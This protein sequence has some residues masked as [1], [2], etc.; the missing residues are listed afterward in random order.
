M[1]AC[2]VTSAAMFLSRRRLE[3]QGLPGLYPFGLNPIAGRVHRSHKTFG[4]L[5]PRGTAELRLRRIEI[6]SPR[7]TKII[8]QFSLVII[9]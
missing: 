7:L 5:I 3:I 8:D 9:P 6:V 2:Q 4:S 1:L